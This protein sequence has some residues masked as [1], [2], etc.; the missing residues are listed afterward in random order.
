MSRLLATLLGGPILAI[1]GAGLALAWP[2]HHG[3]RPDAPWPVAFAARGSM[4][5]TSSNGGRAILA[6]SN[7]GPG[8]SVAG[9]VAIRNTGREAGS[10]SLSPRGL[11]DLPG[12][13]GGVL[14]SA[15]GLVVRD[16]TAHSDAIVFAGKLGS[17]RRRDLGLLAPGGRRAYEF[18]ATLPD[19]GVSPGGEEL[20]GSGLSLDYRWTLSASPPRPC[21]TRLLGDG[22]PNRIVGTVGGD[23]ISGFA[24]RDHLL[25][26]RGAD[27][28]SGGSGRDR[29]SGGAG[30]DT[31]AAA[32]GTRDTIDCGRGGH[33]VAL[34]D[35]LDIVRTCERL[36]HPQRPTK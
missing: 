32:D 17:M 36:G 11:V 24:G 16:V 27:C 23:R 14:S 4:S 29:L 10:L 34:V 20:S 9:G 18:V 35:E 2:A 8:E 5:L 1:T 21:D 13:G 22:G 15:L 30:S 7:L 31:I 19:P 25:G 12:P 33:D 3:G 26:G 28:I 6:A